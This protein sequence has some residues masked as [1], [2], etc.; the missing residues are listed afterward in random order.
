[1]MF[2]NLVLVPL[3]ARFCLVVM[4]PFSAYD[5][6]VHWDE[7]MA[8]AKTSPLPGSGVMLIAAII[9]E[10]VTPVCIVIGWHDRLAAFLLAGFCVVTA[11]LYHQFWKF[12]DFWSK[13][14]AGRSH[15]WDFLK[16]FGLV[17]GLALI[18]IGG[19]F[20]PAGYVLA[21]PLSATPYIATQR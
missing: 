5:K 21:H 6:I 10:F 8:Q 19:G 2:L 12:P 11:L 13:D 18:V 15:F 3:L 17:G 14:G 9:V 4:F 16:N 20:A 1:M 7:A